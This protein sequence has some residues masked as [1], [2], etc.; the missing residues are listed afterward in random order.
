MASYWGGSDITKLGDE[1]LENDLKT[2]LAAEHKAV[3]VSE[4]TR[5]TLKD[6]NKTINEFGRGSEHLANANFVLSIAVFF[7]AWM[8][9]VVQIFQSEY[10]ELIKWTIF[11][12]ITV[13]LL[14]IIWWSS[15][16]IR[17]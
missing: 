11:T 17:K 3:I 14:G 4:L 6:L 10:P 9:L 15:R 2:G 8:Q 1:E 16:R 12:V 7:I 13:G 5:R